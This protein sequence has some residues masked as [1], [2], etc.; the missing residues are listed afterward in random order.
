MKQYLLLLLLLFFVGPNAWAQQVFYFPQI[1]DGTVGNITF[2]TSVIF[3]NTGSNAQISLEFFNSA[4]QPIQLTLLTS[5][6]ALGPSS[7]F[8]IPL[9]S[10]HAFSAQTP[11]TG[12]LQVGYA[13]VTAPATV[14]GTAVFTRSDASTGT[15]L[16]EAGVPA[17]QTLN[18]FSLFLDS[19][20][21]KDTG[22]AIVNPPDGGGQEANLT[23]TL[24]DK[25][26]NQVA[27]TDVVLAAGE[28]RPQFINE[29][30]SDVQE[31][32]REMEGV[33]TLESSGRA[34]A[35]VTLRQNDSPLEFPDEVPTL[36]TFPVVPGAAGSVAAGVFAAVSSNEIKTSLDLSKEKKAALGVVYRFYEGQTVIQE[37]VRS[38]INSEQEGHLV[39]VPVDTSRIDRVEAQLIYTGSELSS[40]FDLSR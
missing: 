28:H 10:G 39:E 15:I 23:L 27:T 13:R 7:S 18:S 9:S 14:G 38:L 29:I 17:S 31:E 30:F 1:G 2:Q 35:A 4:G 19:L 32:A 5:D 20:E 3:V 22:L 37:V 6:S 21:S 33:V 24:Y 40:P 36:T 8:N 12:Q 25:M 34:V 26:F 16:Y 11:G